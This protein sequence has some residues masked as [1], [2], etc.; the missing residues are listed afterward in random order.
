MKINRDN[1]RDY[2]AC[3]EVGGDAWFPEKGEPIGAARNI[4]LNVCPVRAECLDEAL[5]NP[6]THGRH[7]VW[8]GTSERERRTMVRISRKAAA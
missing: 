6:S 5:S 7:G 2:A 4:C 1:W 8:G 3:A